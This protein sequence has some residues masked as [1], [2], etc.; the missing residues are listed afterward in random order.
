MTEKRLIGLSYKELS[1]F[2]SELS[3]MKHELKDES[4]KKLKYSVSDI[5]KQFSKIDPMFINKLAVS[6]TVL[7][8]IRHFTD[9]RLDS[10]GKIKDVDKHVSDMSSRFQIYLSKFRTI[11]RYHSAEGPKHP[12]FTSKMKNMK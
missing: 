11:R 6:R 12:E 7:H 2:I 4:D 8:Y 1:G 10:N 3:K 9:S 5:E